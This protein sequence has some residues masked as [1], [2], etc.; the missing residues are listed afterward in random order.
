MQL[1]IQEHY[2]LSSTVVSLIFLSPFVGYML[3]ATVNNK[4]H[5]TFG[6]RGI[7][8]IAPWCH[9]VPFVIIAIH[10]PYPVVVIFYTVVGFGNGLID[11]A[12][13]AWIGDMARSN[14]ILGFLHGFYGLGATISPL[15]A[16]AMITRAGLGW[17]KFYYVMLGAAVSE[18]ITSVWAF[19]NED[20]ISFRE[21]NPRATD[22]KGGRM[23]ESLQNRVTWVC[24]AFLFTYVGVEGK[25]PSDYRDL[26]SIAYDTYSHTRW[27]DCDFHASSSSRQVFWLRSCSHW[28]L[29]RHY[30]W[31]HYSRLRDRSS[32]RTR[33]SIYLMIS[34]ALQ[35]IFWFVPHFIVSAIAISFLGFFLGPLFPGAIAISTK[36]LP[37]HLHTSSVGFSCALG[38][39]GAAV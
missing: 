1:Q 6:Q 16:T 13:N 20:A 39:G 21:E 31:T 33:I 23:K 22:K 14:E 36:L 32:W 25:S 29:A 11:S 28:F 37:K 24:S 19:W 5:M 18:L 7:T 27:V 12:W 15:I 26:P 3:A 35:L 4:I 2:H 30:N 34:I 38:G 8:I 17:W 10:P 9:I